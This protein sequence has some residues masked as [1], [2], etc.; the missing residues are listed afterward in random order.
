M[1][2]TPLKNKSVSPG[3]NNSANQDLITMYRDN[4]LKL[5]TKGIC[6]S[7]HGKPR[8]NVEDATSWC[9]N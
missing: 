1:I 6:T 3:G 2:F 4:K 5:H 9:A 7:K 8:S